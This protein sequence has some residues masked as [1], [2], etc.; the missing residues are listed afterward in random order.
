MARTTKIV[1]VTTNGRDKG[2]HFL[3]TEMSPVRAEKWASRA[4]LAMANSGADISP[5][6]LKM[7]VGAVLAAGFRSLL[8]MSFVDAE[9]LLDEMMQCVRFMPDRKKP[10]VV[11]EDWEE[12]LEEVSTLLFLRSEVVEVH[13]GFSVAAYL[14]KLGQAATMTTPGSLD[15][16]TSPKSSEQS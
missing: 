5:D 11:R 3:V 7:G 10:D 6:V 14:S 2:K 9:P 16:P 15:T 8:T 12:D 13:T 1:T 4:L